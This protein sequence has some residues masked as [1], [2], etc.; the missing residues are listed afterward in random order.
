MVP[1][2]VMRE[3]LINLAAQLGVAGAFA[4]KIDGSA[5]HGKPTRHVKYFRELKA[6]FGGHCASAV[7]V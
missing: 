7:T 6:R 4:V 5:S 3:H 1:G 2:L